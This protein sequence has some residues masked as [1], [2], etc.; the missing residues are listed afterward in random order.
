MLLVAPPPASW[1]E[2]GFSRDLFRPAADFDLP[3]SAGP[4]EPE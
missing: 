4:N 3:A 2:F 1:K